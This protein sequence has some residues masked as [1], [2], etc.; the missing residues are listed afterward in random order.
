MGGCLTPSIQHRSWHIVDTQK[1]NGSI[2]SNYVPDTMAYHF[3]IHDLYHLIITVFYK[4]DCNSHFI[5]KKI[6]A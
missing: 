1:M 6:E 4:L 3:P 5:D 2:C